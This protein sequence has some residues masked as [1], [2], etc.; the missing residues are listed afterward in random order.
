METIKRAYY[1][2]IPKFFYKAA[3]NHYALLNIIQ[4]GTFIFHTT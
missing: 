2:R 4:F 3:L 1:L